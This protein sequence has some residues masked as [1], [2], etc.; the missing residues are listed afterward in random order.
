MKHRS[1]L[2]LLAMLALMSFAGTSHA[3][4]RFKTPED[5]VSAL[6][7]AVR[8]DNVRDMIMVLGQHG[9]DIVISGD[10]VADQTAR[11]AFLIAYDLKHQIV[12]KD[13]DRAELVI[14]NNDWQLPIP[15]AQKGG[16]W[17]FDAEA[18]RRE[19]LLRRIGRNEL[20]AIQTSLAYVDAQNEYAS[21]NPAGLKVDSYAQRI[22]SSP[23]KKD[24][25]YWPT[26]ANE[27][28]SPLGEAFAAATVQGYR[29]GEQQIPYHGYC[30]KVLTAQGPNAPGGA[31]NYLVKGN[32]IGGF[33]LVAYPAEYGNSG[34]MSF[35]VNHSGVVLQKDLGPN[36]ARIASRMT[37][38]DPD[39][40]WRRVDPKDLTAAK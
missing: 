22:V 37:A 31:M 23:G 32:L 15:L 10:P 20:A 26:A 14:G 38:F 33:G 5:A 12:K 1:R 35:I 3:Q 36:T 13:D 28:Q 34:V 40:S 11:A 16:A 4:Q 8:A 7:A 25:L 2:F 30:Y 39:P 21:M 9:R 6:V 29:P 17:Q 18:G 19:V 27:P 24:G